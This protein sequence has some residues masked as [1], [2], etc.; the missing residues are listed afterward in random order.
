MSTLAKTQIFKQ[1]TEVN[2]SEV[3]SKDWLEEQRLFCKNDSRHQELL[4]LRGLEALRLKEQLSQEPFH[5]EKAARLGE[6]YWRTLAA[7]Y[8]PI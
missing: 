4:R 2:S 5:A 6:R 8:T 1:T 3:T 7:S